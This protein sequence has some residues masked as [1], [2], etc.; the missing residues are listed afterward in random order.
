MPAPR[1]THADISRLAARQAGH[2]AVWQ[3]RMLGASS[4]WAGDQV[5][6]RGWTR[7]H[8]GVL[9][10]A[11]V[12]VTAAGELWAALLTVAPTR[13]SLRAATVPDEQYG[14]SDAAHLAVYRQAAVT[15]FSAAHIRGLRR[16]PPAEPELLVAPDVQ[17]RR[18]GVR[19]VRSA[20]DHAWIETVEGLPV[21]HPS[22]M[23]WD[24]A[25]VQ[26][27]RGG[28]ATIL[29]DTAAALDRTRRFSVD[30][31]L[32]L[33]EEPALFGLPWRRP[34]ALSRAAEL[35][36]PGFSHSGTEARGREIAVTVGRRLGV[37]VTTR[38]H[39][40][41]HGGTVIAEV[42]LGVPELAWGGEVDGPHHDA[43]SVRRHDVRRDALLSRTVSW[44]VNRYSHRLVDAAPDTY[45][46]R[47]TADLRR[48]IADRTS[49]A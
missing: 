39:K 3:L 9:R 24:M 31:L 18:P 40:V 13:A 25:W 33:V 4:S 47:L 37:E 41:W 45:E 12:P 35:L 7:V 46:D 36:R 10:L 32:A 14:R 34:A 44:A 29:G 8:A 48:R 1:S 38:P 20:F 30:E 5:A 27:G 26:R 43:P 17:V 22:R 2:V 16:H 15:G 21:V 11:G 49:V 23:L 28:L 19:L 6:T 42:D